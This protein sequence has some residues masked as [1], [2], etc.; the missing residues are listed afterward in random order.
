MKTKHEIEAEILAISHDGKK[1]DARI[2]ACALDII[3]HVEKHGDTTLADTLYKAMPKGSRRNALADWFFLHGKIRPLIK[4][5]D[6]KDD[7]RLARGDIFGYAKDKTTLL[8]EGSKKPWYECKKEAPVSVAFDVLGEVQ[9]LLQRIE[10]ASKDGKEIKG[11]DDARRLIA[12]KLT[13]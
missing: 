6:E 10:K 11:L 4:G 2:Q 1:M 13:A 9:R 12:E 8:E 3:Q 7:A 5:V